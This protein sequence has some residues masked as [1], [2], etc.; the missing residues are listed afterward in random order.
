MTKEQY[1]LFKSTEPLRLPDILEALVDRGIV[2]VDG[3]SPMPIRV[4]NS[5]HLHHKLDNLKPKGGMLKPGLT[6]LADKVGKLLEM[7]LS[8]LVATKGRVKV[9]DVLSSYS[10]LRIDEP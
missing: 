4:K 1:T 8:S 5:K 3:N 10:R 6:D 7:D 2:R 9:N